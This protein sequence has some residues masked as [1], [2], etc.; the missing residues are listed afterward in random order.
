[1]VWGY[2]LGLEGHR[3]ALHLMP[4]ASGG[5]QSEP[6]LPVWAAVFSPCKLEAT[7]QVSRYTRRQKCSYHSPG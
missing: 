2:R 3:L 6:V 5:K 1:M 7:G 4:L